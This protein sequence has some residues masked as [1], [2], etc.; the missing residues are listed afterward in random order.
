MIRT[1]GELWV[2]R[3]GDASVKM[4]RFNAF[5]RNVNTMNLKI[6]LTHGGVYNF[7][8]KFNKHSGER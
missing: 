3:G 1:W 5:S 4:P 6:F 7:E 8:R 2:G